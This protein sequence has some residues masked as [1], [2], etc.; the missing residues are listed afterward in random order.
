MCLYDGTRDVV[1]VEKR[2]GPRTEPWGTP[3]TGCAVDIS[4]PQATLKDRPVR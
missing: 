4:P 2:R 3:V 1:Y